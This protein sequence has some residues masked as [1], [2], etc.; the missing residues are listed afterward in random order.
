MATF[1]QALSTLKANPIGAGTPLFFREI[2]EAKVFH[3]G[4]L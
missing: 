3:G 2:N 4:L 1:L